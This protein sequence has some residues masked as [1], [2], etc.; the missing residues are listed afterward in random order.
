MALAG[1]ISSF[2]PAALAQVELPRAVPG[3]KLTQQVGLT[4]IG[5]EYDCPA[6]KGRKIWGGVVPFGQLWLMGSGT[7]TKIK[8][9]KDVTIGDR[10]VPAGSYWLLA[11]PGKDAWTVVVNKSAEPIISTHDYKP[12]LDVARVKVAA[13]ASTRRDRL[14]YSF[15]EITDERTSLDLE[16]DA[17]RVSMPI[18]VNTSQQVQAAITGLDTTWRSY[19][20]AARYMLETKKDYDAGLKFIDAAL[21]LKDDWYSMWVKGALL[22]AKGDYGSAH[23]WAVKAQEL[24]TQAG[25]AGALAPELKRSIADW[26]RKSGR[27]DK[28]ASGLPKLGERPGERSSEKL[29]D[30]QL[31]KNGNVPQTPS[32]TP[33]AFSD[34]SAPGADVPVSDPPALRHARLRHR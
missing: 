30:D 10:T 3:A 25:N 15:S 7:A 24:A 4:E 31:A 28:E 29:G 17:V 21:A 26:S 34:S 13:K 22:A 27:S 33:P 11:V 23:D 19:A 8:F 9:S 14:M 6:A 1:A 12:E 5:V 2:A 18:Q 16:W 32:T 20:N